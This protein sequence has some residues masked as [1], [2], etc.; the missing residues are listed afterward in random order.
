MTI[1]QGS[2]SE[3]DSPS[4]EPSTPAACST[5]AAVQ[6]GS[7][8]PP[9]EEVPQVQRNVQ[10]SVSST[11]GMPC[12]TASAQPSTSTSITI[13]TRNIT[14]RKTAKKVNNDLSDDDWEESVSNRKNIAPSYSI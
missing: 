6:S 11:H 12:E 10:P 7:S 1:I 4:D 14:F 13:D 9:H 8:H 3:T 2:D 5:P